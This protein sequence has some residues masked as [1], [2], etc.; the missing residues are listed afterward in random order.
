MLLPGIGQTSQS[1]LGLEHDLSRSFDVLCLDLPGTGLALDEK[2]LY[3]VQQLAWKCLEVLAALKLPRLYLVGNNLGALIALE[4]SLHLPVDVLRGLIL[5]SPSHSSLGISRSTRKQ[6]RQMQK[7]FAAPLAQRQQFAQELWLGRTEADCSLAEDYPAQF[8]HWLRQSEAAHQQT[9]S[10][11]HFAQILAMLSYTSQKP[12]QHIRLFQIPFKCLIPTH[13]A[14]V[15]R[16]HAHQVY[17][18]LKHPQS[19][20]IELKN[21]GHDLV[22]T[23]RRQVFDI[24]SQFVKEHATYRLYPAP[25]SLPKAGE[26]ATEKKQL[27]T[28]LGLISLGM[29]VLTWLFKKKP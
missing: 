26:K 16:E 8:E 15:P 19:A 23:H 14:L 12:F 13:S 11:A 24:I 9:R 4:I 18:Q 27:Y 20:F 3:T 7:A 6:L 17:Q 29:L 25:S 5:L 28:S 10:Q 2:P 1:W 22:A 21:G